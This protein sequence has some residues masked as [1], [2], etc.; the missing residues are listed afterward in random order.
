MLTA[1]SRVLRAVSIFAAAETTDIAAVTEDVTAILLMPE[2][3]EARVFF[4][5]LFAKQGIEF[6]Q[7]DLVHILLHA[8]HLLE[9]GT[10]L[11]IELWHKIRQKTTF[12][13]MRKDLVTLRERTENRG[14][15]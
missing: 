15:L 10:K 4:V 5:R 12:V 3:I 14:E 13:F 7:L 11:Q 8:R 6:K 1:I 9:M 2:S